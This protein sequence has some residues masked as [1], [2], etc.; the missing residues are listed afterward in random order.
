MS[1]CLVDIKSELGCF[2]CYP[3]FRLHLCVS[4]IRA[5]QQ[6][7]PVCVLIIGVNAFA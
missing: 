3:V 4:F 7:G 1:I 5:V 2:A 6:M